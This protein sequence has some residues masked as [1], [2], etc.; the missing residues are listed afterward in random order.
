NFLVHHNV[1]WNT[2]DLGIQTNLDAVN[3]Q[4]YHN[5]IW[6]CGQ[7][8]GGGGGTIHRNC[9][10]YNN[11]S[12]APGWFGTDLQQNLILDDPR[13]VDAAAG[14]F[15]L[16]ADSPARDDYLPLASFLNGGFESG[17]GGW[18]GA[19]ASIESITDPVHSGNRACRSYNRHYYWEGVRQDVTEVLK[20][21]GRGNYTIEAW[22]MPAA[23]PVDGYLRFFIEDENGKSYP[24]TTKR[25]S[26][27]V[28]TKITYKTTLNWKGE[29]KQAVFELMTSN[30]TSLPDLYID[31][32]SL[33][34]PTPTSS[35]KP[36]GAVRLPGINDDALDGKP[37]AGAYEYGGAEADWKAG[38]SLKASPSRVKFSHGP[39]A[40]PNDLILFSNYPNPFNSSTTLRFQLERPAFVELAIFD[41]SGRQTAVLLGGEMPAGEFSLS[42]DG[43]DERGL[44]VG[45]GVYFCRCTVKDGQGERSVSRKMILV[46]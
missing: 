46:K 26:P 7:A 14:D 3:H 15:R 29:L 37:D 5:T 1:V 19:G 4:I 20:D 24:G 33:V 30:D 40:H 31:D 9:R 28:W 17:T 45:S 22:V 35:D 6:N 41:L 18:H 2:D 23:G 13:F 16:Q 8:M 27:G 32:C 12:N 39:D 21:H 25:L 11:L 36:R 10:V 44:Q 38:S 42:W 34:A 43:R